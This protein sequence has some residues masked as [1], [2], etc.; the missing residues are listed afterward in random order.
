MLH[1]KYSTLRMQ[2]VIDRNVNQAV[3]ERIKNEDREKFFTALF[4]FPSDDEV[5]A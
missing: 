2:E 4:Q 5:E 3:Y 1:A